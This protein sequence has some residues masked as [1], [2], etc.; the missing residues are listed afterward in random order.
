VNRDDGEGFH[1][2]PG[3]PWHPSWSDGT[4][5]DDE[6]IDAPEP[7]EG[8]GR[9]GFLK[10]LLGR[11]GDDQ[12]DEE[13]SADHVYDPIRE[14]GPLADDDAPDHLEMTD[15]FEVVAI[16]DE[17]EPAPPEEDAEEPTIEIPLQPESVP[18]LESEAE[19][20]LLGDVSFEAH[21]A[22]AAGAEWALDEEPDG[23]ISDA[24]AH[25][26]A[27]LG[28]D[29]DVEER[30]ALDAEIQYAESTV[31]EAEAD[32]GG[33]SAAAAARTAADEA[34]GEDASALHREEAA[35]VEGAVAAQSDV[36]GEHGRATEA[37]LADSDELAASGAT[38]VEEGAAAMQIVDAAASE[39]ADVGRADEHRSG[40]EHQAL[41]EALLDEE[42]DRSHREAGAAE[43]DHTIDEVVRYEHDVAA[44]ETVHARREEEAELAAAMAAAIEAREHEAFRLGT[45]DAATSFVVPEIDME[46]FQFEA[47][48][49]EEP[50]AADTE[51]PRPDAEMPPPDDEVPIATPDEDDGDRPDEAESVAEPVG[52][53][54]DRRRGWRRFFFRSRAASGVAAEAADSDDQALASPPM[55]TDS[56][57]TDDETGDVL[58]PKSPAADAGDDPQLVPA[59]PDADFEGWLGDRDDAYQELAA[60]DGDEEIAGWMAFTEGNPTE[61]G[62][63]EEGGDL[64]EE[65]PVAAG[66]DDD[67]VVDSEDAEEEEDTSE[68]FLGDG[69][70]GGSD[71]G[72]DDEEEP[73]DDDEEEP[74][75]DDE[76]EPDDDDDEDDEEGDEVA[77]EGLT[78]GEVWGTEAPIS[79]DIGDQDEAAEQ[80]AETGEVVVPIG[81]IYPLTPIAADEPPGD[82]IVELGFDAFEDLTG[83]DYLAS[84]STTRDHTGLAEAIAAAEGEV[85]EQVALSASFPGLESGVVGFE[86]VVV[87]EDQYAGSASSPR[88][89][90]LTVRVGSA[91]LLIVV[92]LAALLYRPALIGLA[93]VVFLL[94][95]GEFYTVLMRRGYRPLALFGFIG[96]AAASLGT[97][98][99]GVIAIPMALALT[100]MLILLYFAVAPGRV[101]PLVNYSITIAVAGWV[102]LGAF[103]FPIIESERYRTLVL[104]VVATVA[105]MDIASYFVGRTLGRNPLAP[106]VSPKK[107]WEG[108]VGGVVV[109]L[110]IGA[111]LHYF[112]PFE[113]TSGLLF[114]AVVAVVAPL[115]DLAVSVVKRALAVKDMGAVLP[116]HGGLF[117]RIDALI[118]VIPAAWA[119][120]TWLELL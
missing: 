39:A 75:D 6:L 61:A 92:F 47:P 58:L 72:D 42:I 105:I 28:R 14:Q 88:A 120:F 40:N 41:Q 118:F 71:D 5:D 45:D 12:E 114:G 20:E 94:S 95:A 46:G 82:D 90:D 49:P 1:P 57:G 27:D 16:R 62:P 68:F 73:D 119:L 29:M 78:P 33:E 60:D 9:A 11:P 79:T 111:L 87:A 77:D 116:G 59:G 80:D 44:A 21:S 18:E 110:L 97:V 100:S 56:R 23:H 32:H 55:A 98:V 24:A 25:L 63:G 96:L 8:E 52:G 103:A 113:L 109:A 74:D 102:G 26:E 99:W 48:E 30:E 115:G 112:P 7:R 53:E 83:E 104:A 81:T 54:P 22:G 3:D 15:E 43:E 107:T 89:S 67:T 13:R 70:D 76:E 31:R 38:D 106:V 86:D 17:P 4:D 37:L 65:L 35:S 69:D 50:V 51:T 117:D 36:A 101:R 93:L 84:G 91:V 85:T 66:D 34:E 10:R 19:T 64:T 108:L 2:H